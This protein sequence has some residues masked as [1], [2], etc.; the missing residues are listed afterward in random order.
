MSKRIFYRIIY[1]TL[2]IFFLSLDL[3]AQSQNILYSAPFDSLKS[4]LKRCNEDN[5]HKLRLLN[6]IAVAYE[7]LDAAKGVETAMQAIALAQKLDNKLLLAEAYY[8]RGICLIVL[9]RYDEADIFLRKALA[10]NK[11]IGNQSGE[12]ENL[13]MI[14]DSY[15]KKGN[16]KEAISYFEKAYSLLVKLNSRQEIAR[17]LYVIGGAYVCNNSYS[18]AIQSFKTSAAIYDSLKKPWSSA[19]NLN[20]IGEIFHDLSELDSALHYYNKA[21]SLADPKE[22]KIGIANIENSIGLI[23]YS[24]S[25][26][27]DAL[28]MFKKSLAV[29]VEFNNL[30]DIPVNLGNIAMVHSTLGNTDTAFYYFNQA[31]DLYLEQK[32]LDKIATGLYNIGMF[33]AVSGEHVKALEYY[34]KALSIT[35]SIGLK[36]VTEYIHTALGDSYKS[37]GHYQ[38]AIESFHRA[39]EIRH[40]LGKESGDGMILRNI[41]EL[42]IDIGDYKA[43]EQYLSKALDADKAIGDKSGISAD[44]GLI[45]KMKHLKSNYREALTDNFEALQL[46]KDIGY[47]ALIALH[48]FQIG[49]NYTALKNYPFA[50]EKYFAASTLADSLDDKSLSASINN[51]LGEVYAAQQDWVRSFSFLHKGRNTAHVL[52][53]LKKEGEAVKLLSGAHEKTGRYDSAYFYH[54]NYLAIRDSIASEETQK[55]ITRKEMQYAFSKKE[56]EYRLQQKIDSGKLKEKEQAYIISSQQLALR[57]KELALSNQ[58]K[59]LQRLEYL[60]EKAEKQEKEMSLAKMQYEF[61]MAEMINKQELEQM[62]AAGLKRTEEERIRKNYLAGA[63]AFLILFGTS[64]WIIISQR[65]KAA[66][67]EKVSDTEMRALRAQMNPHFIFNALNSVYRYLQLNDRKAA[68]DYLMNFSQLTRLVLENSMYP[69]VT[70]E[71]ELKALELYLTL[72]SERLNNRFNFSIQISDEIDAGNTMIPPLLLQPFVENSVWHGL[73]DEAKTGEI[74]ITINQLNNQLICVIED[75]GV[76]RKK[77]IG[78]TEVFRKGRKSV[79]MSLTQQRIDIINKTKGGQASVSVKDLS[80]MDGRQTGVRVELVLPLELAS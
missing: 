61:G 7:L 19:R 16:C 29:H 14:G 12:A 50:L 48:Q 72:E 70:L 47:K 5:V 24:R 60:K 73:S 9:A 37:L 30:K 21:I 27:K 45:G 59:D 52:G 57:N 23:Y 65:R 49:Q 77:M 15:Q 80:E 2:P 31:L 64:A 55:Q 38:M 10:I 41:G 44:L 32:A 74:N 78:H 66:F 63:L 36:V 76:G 79:G 1:L 18:K 51:A 3:F 22:N 13:V 6:R 17:S 53:L 8:N 68:E 40:E 62:E 26:Y 35:D 75:N 42:Y 56:A 67:R 46:A 34:S 28:D 58:E 20:S 54:K 43:A 71:D 39:L 69:S 25:Q 4:E 11:E 33:W